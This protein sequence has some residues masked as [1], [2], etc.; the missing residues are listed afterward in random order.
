M[1]GLS[2]EHKQLL[3][4]IL[5]DSDVSF[6][7]WAMNEIVFW[8]NRGVPQ[9]LIQIHGTNDY[10]LPMQKPDFSIKNGGHLMVLTEAD[11]VSEML[12]QLCG[13]NLRSETGRKIIRSTPLNS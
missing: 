12:R 13:K 1:V 8:Q 4:Q 7:K 2:K 10:I 6:V 3:K 5:A 9:N 11:E